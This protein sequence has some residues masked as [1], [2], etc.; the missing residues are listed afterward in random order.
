MIAKPQIKEIEELSDAELGEIVAKE[1]CSS[2]EF[3]DNSIA[4]CWG[5]TLLPLERVCR[6]CRAMREL[7]RRYPR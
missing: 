7:K 2:P 3:K 1:A 4:K 6:H 5:R